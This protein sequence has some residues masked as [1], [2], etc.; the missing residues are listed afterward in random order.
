MLYDPA[1]FAKGGRISPSAFAL[2]NKGKNPDDVLI[3]SFDQEVIVM[4]IVPNSCW[5]PIPFLF[6]R[7]VSQFV[8]Y[9]RTST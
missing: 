5:K 3:S 7:R 6:E 2:A 9:T 4:S 1:L 8:S